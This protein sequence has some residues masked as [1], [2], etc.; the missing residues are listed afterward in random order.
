MDQPKNT[1]EKCLRRA[2]LLTVSIV[3]TTYHKDK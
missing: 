2:S 1:E 3:A